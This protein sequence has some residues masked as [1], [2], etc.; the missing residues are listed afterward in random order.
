VTERSDVEVTRQL[1]VFA[2]PLRLQL[3]SLLTGQALSAAEAARAL[4]CSQ[5]N[6][7]Y[8]L[9]VLHAAGLLDIVERTSV[10]GGRAVRYR[11]DPRSG[12]RVNPGGPEGY[13]VLVEVLGEELRRR[14]RDRDPTA[15]G[16]T[17]DAELWVPA[18]EWEGFL[19]VLGALS[20]RLHA[21]ARPARTPGAVR[22]S[23]TI[24]AFRMRN[25]P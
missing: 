10:R 17:T 11:H 6:A 19:A 25:R 12:D 22:T 18:Q 9:R 15:R 7:S 14:S 23:T 2:H 3:M 16:V 13:A 20:L 4:R 5:A 21:A 8:H 1:R 24:A